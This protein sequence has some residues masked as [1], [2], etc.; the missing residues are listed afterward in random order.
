MTWYTNGVLVQRSDRQGLA[1][2]ECIRN[3]RYSGMDAYNSFPLAE[4][5]DSEARNLS[6]KVFSRK[7]AHD[8]YIINEFITDPFLLISY[9]GVCQKRQIP[10][11]LL[12][13]ESSYG[14]E[15]WQGI[16]PPRIFW[17]YEYNSIPI[18]NQIITDLA[19][20][21]PFADFWPKLNEHGL[22]PSLESVMLFKRTY[23]RAFMDGKIG[24]GDMDAY[25]FR[26]S[27]VDP[28]D[29]L[30]NSGKVI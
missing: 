17:G 7:V 5:P 24:D 6:K 28:K 23:D 15:I 25:I 22:F 11:Q 8:A 21:P 2:G 9:V 13:V 1:V 20:Y 29:I 3:F 18:D 27:V 14:R 30:E 16:D 10:L 12:F 26:L 4:Y 19:W